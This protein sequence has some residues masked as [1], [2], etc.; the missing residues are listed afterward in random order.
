MG[1]RIIMMKLICLLSHFECDSHPVHKL[2]Q[3]PLTAGQLAPRESDCS[4]MHSKVFSDWLPSYIKALRPV[5]EI[6]RMTGYFPDSPP[7]FTFMT[8]CHVPLVCCGCHEASSILRAH[9]SVHRVSNC[10]F[11]F[12]SSAF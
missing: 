11:I 9:N 3:Q 7:I 8:Y 2:S 6:F 5:L 12:L 1:R 4:W 10:F